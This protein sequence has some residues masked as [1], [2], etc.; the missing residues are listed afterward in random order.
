MLVFFPEG[1]RV[2][3]PV[4]HHVSA[5]TQTGQCSVELAS[6]QPFFSSYSRDG[7]TRVFLR[8]GYQ[9]EE[10]GKKTRRVI[11]FHY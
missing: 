1:R 7:S 9:C 5:Q 8:L 3:C 10:V 6:S 11:S 4:D 2:P